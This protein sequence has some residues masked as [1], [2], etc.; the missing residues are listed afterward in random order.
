[1]GFQCRKSETILYTLVLAP[2]TYKS[3]D[4]RF[5]D[6]NDCTFKQICSVQFR[7]FRFT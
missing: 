5:C 7:C 4:I 2:L 1:M 3:S 6:E